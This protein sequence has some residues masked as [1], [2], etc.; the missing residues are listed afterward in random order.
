MN[1]NAFDKNK[2]TL[3]CIIAFRIQG[4]LAF[5]IRLDFLPFSEEVIGDITVKI[6]YAR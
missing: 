2:N 1:K 5:L 3:F 4:M 6:A